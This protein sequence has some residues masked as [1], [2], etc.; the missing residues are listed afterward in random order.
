[1][2]Y[3]DK[4]PVLD[5]VDARVVMQDLYETQYGIYNHL[6]KDRNRPLASVAF[7]DVEDINE[8]SL[9]EEAIRTYTLRGIGEHT[10]LSLVE[11]LELPSDVVAMIVKICDE[12]AKKKEKT[13]EEV[14]R[15]LGLNKR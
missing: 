5:S 2:E 10:R 1:M 6:S 8:G 15:D 7:H 14:E 4:L 3:L 9:L 11:F 12:I 13:M